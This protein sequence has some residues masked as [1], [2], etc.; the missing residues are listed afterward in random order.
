MIPAPL[1]SIPS[2]AAKARMRSRFGEPLLLASWI[3]TLMVHLEVDPEA[4]QRATPFP[5]DLFDQRAFVSLVFFTMRR[6]RPRFGGRLTE[7]VLRPIATHDFLNVRTYVRC[8][9]EPGIY[10]LAEWLPNAL[11]A[12]L[13]PGIFGLP[14]RL[15][16]THYQLSRNSNNLVGATVIDPASQTR[17][18]CE[19]QL[20]SATF[21]PCPADSIDEWL[22]ERYTAFTECR[23]ISRFFR[24]WHPP[25]PQVPAKVG[26]RDT[27]LLRA[28]WPWMADREPI[29]ANYSPGFNT[30]WM[31]RPHRLGGQ[32]GVAA[33]Q[34]CAPKFLFPPGRSTI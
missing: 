12:R 27:S 20:V 19:G 3:D 9:D 11:S 24:V 33:R 34:S 6:M 30:V 16:Q 28:R 23:G 21:T 29:G 15:G 22:M 31:G 1:T 7:W 32:R 8:C 5:L 17:L 4:L 25:W 10:F 18:S 14:Y 26:L 13:G 2:R